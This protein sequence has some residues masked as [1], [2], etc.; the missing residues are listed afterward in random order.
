MALAFCALWHVKGWQ[1]APLNALK[2]RRLWLHWL[3]KL[4]RGLAEVLGN[5][6]G[7]QTAL[8]N[9]LKRWGCRGL[10]GSYSAERRG[11]KNF[12]SCGTV[13]GW[14]TAPLNALK[15]RMLWLHWLVKLSKGLA[16]VLG[17]LEGWQTAL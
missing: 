17:S 12:A 1:T 9:A 11:F 14:Q 6:E 4:P 3:V 2:S 8:L 10:T 7:W 13:K 5:F 15:S 16:K